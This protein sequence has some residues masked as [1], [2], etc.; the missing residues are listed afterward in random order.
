MRTQSFFIVGG[1]VMFALSFLDN[2]LLGILAS[3]VSML[4]FSVSIGMHLERL[5]NGSPRR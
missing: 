1:W 3:L 2:G 4:C 5:A